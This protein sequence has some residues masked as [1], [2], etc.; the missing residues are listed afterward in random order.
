MCLRYTLFNFQSNSGPS[1]KQEYV[2]EDLFTFCKQKERKV[3]GRG[4][5]QDTPK[6]YLLYFP[7]ILHLLKSLEHLQIALPP[8]AQ[9]FE[10]WTFRVT[11]Y[12]KS[13]QACPS[14]AYFGYGSMNTNMQI[15]HW[16]PYFDCFGPIPFFSAGSYYLRIFIHFPE[17]LQ[18]CF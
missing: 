4:Q 18:I 13:L 14:F 1:W 8:R 6:I 12:A 7:A 5:K 2:V 3:T 15:S 17:Q 11:F 10:T 16:D 9:A